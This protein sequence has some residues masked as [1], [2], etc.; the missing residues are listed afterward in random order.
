MRRRRVEVPVGLLDVLAVV[1][2]V[3]AQAEQALLENR[4]D[5]VPEGDREVQP[6]L[7]VADPQQAVLA[8]AVRTRAGVIVGQVLPCR[9]VRRVVLAD[10][11]PLALAEIG[12]PAVPGLAAG[13][14]ICKPQR[15]GAAHPPIST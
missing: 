13:V 1:A 3:A 10:R 9:P 6:A 12:T 2:L 8:P 7:V 15:L 4:V 11:A 14:L 5:A